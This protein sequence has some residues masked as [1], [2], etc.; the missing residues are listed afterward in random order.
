[1]RTLTHTA[2]PITS[3]AA[4]SYPLRQLPPGKIWR[5]NNYP[6]TSSPMLTVPT[7]F[8]TLTLFAG[9]AVAALG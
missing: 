8:Y 4:N 2:Y 7:A 9:D 1:L 5:V 6:W 3:V